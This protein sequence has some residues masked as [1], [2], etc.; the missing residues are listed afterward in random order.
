MSASLQLHGHQRSVTEVLRKTFRPEYVETINVL[1]GPEKTLFAV[2]KDPICDKSPF[3]AAACSGRWDESKDGTVRLDFVDADTFKLY[4][5]WVYTARLDVHVIEPSS[6][7]ELESR[8]QKFP[9]WEPTC[10][11]IRYAMLLCK[12]YIAAGVLL[13]RHLKNETIDQLLKTSA[14]PLRGVHSDCINHVWSNTNVDSGLRRCIVDCLAPIISAH[15][16]KDLSREALVDFVAKMIELRRGVSAAETP[17]FAD[18]CEYHE[19]AEDE[20]RCTPQ[21]ST[22]GEL[23]LAGLGEGSRK[24]KASGRRTGNIT[25]KTTVEGLLKHVACMVGVHFLRPFGAAL[26]VC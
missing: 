6:H 3:F 7:E 2:H 8:L 25:G 5:H 1:V 15:F 14:Y 18:R 10:L 17:T 4:I 22:E 9:Y 21:A 19:H 20:E 13:D 16:V 11:D 24:T 12:T 26:L 23:E